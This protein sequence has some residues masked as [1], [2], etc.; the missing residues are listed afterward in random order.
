MRSKS[1]GSQMLHVLRELYETAIVFLYP[2][3]CRVCET[4]LE[5]TSVPYICNNCW[6]DIQF[7]EP[8]WCDICGTPNMNG[9][10]NDCAISPP[11]YGKLRS[12]AVYQTT[13]RQ[14][15]HLFK[16]EKKKVFTQ[17]LIHLMNA[18]SPTD[19]VIEEYDFILPVPIHKKRLH[20]RGFNQSTLLAEGIAQAKGVPVLTDVLIRHRH[21]AAQ[22]SLQRKARQQNVIGAFGIQHSDVLRNKR[23]LIVDDIFTTGATIREVVN[24]LWRAHPAEVDVLTLA[25]TL[26]T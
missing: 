25:R 7:L 22:T 10:C 17:H 2:A 11:R 20:A 21:T 24:E 18:H 6:H 1:F 3:R 14:A 5:V 12:I 13:L 8:P 9:L 26:R 19:C 4:S 15:I 16:F 23:L